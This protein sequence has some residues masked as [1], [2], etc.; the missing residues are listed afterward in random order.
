MPESTKSLLASSFAFFIRH[1]HRL[2][3]NSSPV[4]SYWSSLY[5][6]ESMQNLDH[7][8][9]SCINDEVVIRQERHPKNSLMRGVG[10]GEV[11]RSQREWIHWLI[12]HSSHILSDCSLALYDVSQITTFFSHR[13]GLGSRE[14]EG[15]EGRIF[16]L[17]H[18]FT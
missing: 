12:R 5:P 1:L 2:L 7:S 18:L 3:A 13:Q 11:L 16:Y 6:P 15:I 9:C 8:T 4:T 14:L 10:S 17:L